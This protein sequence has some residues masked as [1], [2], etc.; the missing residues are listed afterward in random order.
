VVVRVPEPALAEHLTRLYAPLVVDDRALAPHRLSLTATG[1]GY[2]VHLDATRLLA[3]PARSI[4]FQSL[5][6]HANRQAI[7]RSRGSVLVHAAAAATGG[8]AIVLTGPMG[9]GKS[10]L[11]AALVRAGLEYLTDEVVAIDPGSGLV[12]PYPKY[13]SLAGTRAADRA[14]GLREHLGDGLVAPDDLRPGAAAH[15]PARPRVVVTPRYEPGATAALEPLRP[16]AALAALAQHAFHLERD[17]PR[18]LSVLAGLV[19]QSACYALV[20][21]DVPSATRLLLDL[22]DAGDRVRT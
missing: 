20:S 19:E 4:A 11:V 18:T 14:A 17:A 6:W 8:T 3:T 2:E 15:G 1:T 10:T 7:D 5:L 22:V 21:G 13:L 16:A 9:A 12:R